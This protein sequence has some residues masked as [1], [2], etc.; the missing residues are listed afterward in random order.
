MHPLIQCRMLQPAGEGGCAYLKHTHGRASAGGPARKATA[1]DGRDQK[2][3][4][5][6]AG[7]VQQHMR[8]LPIERRRRRR[9]R[10]RPRWKHVV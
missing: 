2:P 3:V 1:F 4:S 5:S 9:R 6:A 8:A 7:L 10:R